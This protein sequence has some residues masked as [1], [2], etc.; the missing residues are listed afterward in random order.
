MSERKRIPLVEGNG[1]SAPS[2]QKA[3]GNGT[4]TDLKAK[5]FAARHTPTNTLDDGLHEF[6]RLCAKADSLDR[7]AD[8]LAFKAYRA[9][10]CAAQVLLELRGRVEA[11]EAGEITWW[12]WFESH[13]NRSRK[14]AEKLLVIAGAD[15]PE[16]A[17]EAARAKNAEHQRAHRARTP[18]YVS[19]KPRK[20]P[21][22]FALG[23]HDDG[24]KP[25][26]D[27]LILGLGLFNDLA[28]REEEALDKAVDQQLK[29]EA[30]RT[31]FRTQVLHALR[32]MS[33]EELFAL[34]H[35]TFDLVELTAR[36]YLND[37]TE[38]QRREFDAAIRQDAQAG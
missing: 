19:G 16:A 13:S 9:R 6:H 1:T 21:G 27:K 15:D 3:K 35:E 17:A 7:R 25:D 33:D 10:L 28:Q 32:K 26:G 2:G 24:P 14:D 4:I 30:L 34:I 5:G 22:Q 18:A 36:L 37:M 23:S 20:N 12:A 29:A 8:G 31:E 11:G 38:A